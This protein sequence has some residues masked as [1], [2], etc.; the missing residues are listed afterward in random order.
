VHANPNDLNE[1]LCDNRM[2]SGAGGRPVSAGLAR[3]LRSGPRPE[4]WRRRL[5]VSASKGF[6]LIEVLI[7]MVII[8]ILATLA[9]PRFSSTV[10]KSTDAAAISDLRNAMSAEEA[11]LVDN[12]TY[13]LISNLAI[14]T[15]TGVSIGGGGTTGG[16]VLTAHHQSSAS[17]YAVTVGGSSTTEGKIIKQ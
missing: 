12:S 8:A 2:L 9:L 17:T 10:E 14:T 4:P 16:Y 13:A 15:S 6:T 3:P 11:Y 5:P 7:V 1:I